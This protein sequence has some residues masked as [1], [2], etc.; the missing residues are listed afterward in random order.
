MTRFSLSLF[1]LFLVQ[2]VAS[3][4]IAQ[5]TFIADVAATSGAAATNGSLTLAVWRGYAADGGCIAGR[6]FDNETLAP[7]GER[8][9]VHCGSE[10]GD[11]AVAVGA[12][13][14]V[15]TWGDPSGL[16]VKRIDR[17]GSAIGPS[18]KVSA[19]FMLP[20]AEYR[21]TSAGNDFL[22]VWSGGYPEVLSVAAYRGGVLGATRGV[23]QIGG[24]NDPAIYPRVVSDGASYLVS[25][26]RVL[27][28]ALCLSIC[29]PWAHSAMRF[30]LDGSPLDDVSFEIP[31]YPHSRAVHRSV[32][33]NGNGY[34]ALTGFPLDGY[35]EPK[36]TLSQIPRSGNI[37]ATSALAREGWQSSPLAIHRRGNQ[38]LLFSDL[39][40]FSESTWGELRT[41][42]LIIR[43]IS[44]SGTY[45][46]P[47]R[48]LP[49]SPNR[50][51]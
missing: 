49:L 15:V 6:Y 31:S 8:F 36:L 14:S 26:V 27:P 34:L 2:F 37:T 30:A 21:V 43:E 39:T 3:K 50:R 11:P 20:P 42:F 19:T 40:P 4:G 13:E 18:T 46:G 51:L 9:V 32:I 7:V 33:A 45:I 1:L 23:P 24:R 48:G 35:D 29:Y 47:V 28:G 41:S 38:L 22:I 44:A 25:Y 10:L 12:S 16:Y 5:E 17:Q